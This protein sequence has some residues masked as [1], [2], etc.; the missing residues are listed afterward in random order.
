MVYVYLEYK[1]V[2]ELYEK[3]THDCGRLFARVGTAHVGEML[4][5][6]L[7]RIGRSKV[8]SDTTQRTE[9]MVCGIRVLREA[10]CAESA[11]A[12]R[13]LEHVIDLEFLETNRTVF[14][15]MRVGGYVDVLWD[16]AREFGALD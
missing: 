6:H 7:A 12:T 16:H 13:A 14:R 9:V 15:D 1:H 3:Y 2:H 11:R 5:E 8:N 4:F 10:I